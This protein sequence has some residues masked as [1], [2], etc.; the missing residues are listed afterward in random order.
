M[1]VS[2]TQQTTQLLQ[3]E[4]L[5]PAQ[6]QQSMEALLR[7]DATDEDAKAWLLAMQEK[8]ITAA[9]LA[10]AQRVVIAHCAAFTAMPGAMDCCGTGGDGGHTLNVSTATAIV[11][12]ACGVQ[13]VKHGN[14]AVSSKSGSA[15]VLQALGINL[16]APTHIL[17]RTARELNL[18]FLFA[19]QFHPALARIAPLRRAMGTRT[20]F[21]ILGP[22]CNPARPHTQLIGVYNTQVMQVVAECAREIGLTHALIVHSDDGLDECSISAVTHALKLEGETITEL[23]ITPE[24]AGLPRHAADALRGGDAAHNA[25]AL[26]ALLAGQLSAYRDA[27]L[28]NVAVALWLKK[29]AK[30]LREGAQMAAHAIDSGAAKQ[31]LASYQ[32]ATL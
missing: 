20:L 14:R 22:L 30:S 25:A 16:E 2:L 5:S 26:H 1:P 21:N 6:I 28:L 32:A 3:R 18:A 10:S 7:G 29:Q 24:D 17:E 8:P 23:T 11:L 4:T 31:L 15:D 13:V 9:E 12:A 19:P 27:V